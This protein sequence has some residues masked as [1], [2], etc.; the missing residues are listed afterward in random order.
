MT[1][2]PDDSSLPVSSPVRK[3]TLAESPS[4][5]EIFSSVPIP[6]G[7]SWFRK[8]FAFAGPAYL[9]SVGYMDPG[10]WATD[11]EGGSRF[12]YQLVWVLL[13]SNWMAILLQT[14]ASR[15]GL[16]AGRDL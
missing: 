1:Q 16:F 6:T 12:G 11:I 9:V 14:L 13:L 10:N 8:L 15:L 7:A 2:N 4:L 3:A 5:P